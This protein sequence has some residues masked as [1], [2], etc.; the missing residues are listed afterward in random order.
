M[1]EWKADLWSSASIPAPNDDRE[2][3][4]AVVF[5]YLVAWFLGD[6]VNN[7]KQDPLSTAELHAPETPL[8]PTLASLQIPK[9]TE[10][11]DQD[12]TL[13]NSTNSLHKTP[14]VI[15][16][17]H[18]WLAG[19]ALTLIKCRKIDVATIF[20]THATLLGR[21]LCAGDVD[22]YNNLKHFDVD[23]EAGKRGIYHRYCV[24]RASAHCADVF[25]TVSHITAYEAEYLLK[26]KP[27][28]RYHF[29]VLMV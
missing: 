15:A 21:Y 16:H 27:G 29:N 14:A 10:L 5:G 24:E 25:T 2:M 26:R 28:M 1:D 23:H 19:V 18:E 22:F 4:E 13:R 20:T 8:T 12:Q 11:H 3:N 17:F 9:I 7:L 6:F